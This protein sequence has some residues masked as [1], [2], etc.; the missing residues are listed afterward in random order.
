MSDDSIE[1]A[2]RDAMSG[3][4]KIVAK[5]IYRKLRGLGCED[6]DMIAV[7]SALLGLAADGIRSDEIT[8]D[9]AE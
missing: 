5:T 2:A 3:R 4:P 8:A 9:A 7:A 1:R 6:R